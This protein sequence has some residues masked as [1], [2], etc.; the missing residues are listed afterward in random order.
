M[1]VEDAFARITDWERH[2]DHIPLTT[3]TVTS[4]GPLGVGSTFVGRTGLGP[5]RFDDPMTITRW[6][7]PHGQEPGSCRLDK[8]G[9]VVL[10]WAEIE[11]R[12]QGSGSLVLWTEE[13]RVRGLP[14][15]FDPVARAGGQWMFGRAIDRMLRG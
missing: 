3:V 13:A 2:S 7:P 11:V 8:T 1:S 14:E 15:I 10:G 6:Q 5:L 12:P 4:T 9:S